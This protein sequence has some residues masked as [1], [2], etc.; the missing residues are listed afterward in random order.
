MAYAYPDSLELEDSNDALYQECD[1]TTPEK[2][3]IDPPPPYTQGWETPEPIK[4]RRLARAKS[5]L[6]PDL[7][8]VP[9]NSEVDN[10]STMLEAQS[11][12]PQPLSPLDKPVFSMAE[13][14]GMDPR[15]PSTESMERDIPLPSRELGS[16]RPDKLDNF[17]PEGNLLIGKI[18][19]LADDIDKFARA[20]PSVME[21][22]KI[23]DKRHPLNKYWKYDTRVFCLTYIQTY[24]ALQIE[25]LE[26]YYEGLLHIMKE[27][28]GWKVT[29]KYN[30]MLGYAKHSYGKKFF[31]G[32]GEERRVLGYYYAPS[33]QIAESQI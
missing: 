10:I 8:T 1:T 25:R 21:S 22:L 14:G 11:L 27:I 18:H 6:F 20:H 3:I 13:G 28:S 19:A 5:R 24:E 9:P 16:L 30:R 23:K 31:R 32:P 33:N 7:P 26:N 4:K 12:Y 29:R 15:A 2:D 17:Q